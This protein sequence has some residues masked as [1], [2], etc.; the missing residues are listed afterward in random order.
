MSLP[1]CHRVT[2][3]DGA[4]DLQRHTGLNAFTYAVKRPSFIGVLNIARE[5]WKNNYV[6]FLARPA[7]WTCGLQN[8]FNV[9]PRSEFSSRAKSRM[10]KKPV[11]MD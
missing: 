11:A 4:V 1:G 8:I 2:G 9:D 6:Q 7:A 10:Q 3:R 5:F